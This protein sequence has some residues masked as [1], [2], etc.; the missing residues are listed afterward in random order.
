MGNVGDCGIGERK[1]DYNVPL[2]EEDASFD[3][4]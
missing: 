2:C 1:N 4:V 3:M